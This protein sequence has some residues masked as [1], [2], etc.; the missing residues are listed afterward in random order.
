MT[1]VTTDRAGAQKNGAT[2]GEV[3]AGKLAEGTKELGF[4]RELGI[5]GAQGAGETQ[6]AQG[7]AKEHSKGVSVELQTRRGRSR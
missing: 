5:W 6:H 3:W 2:T 1:R 7:T 4:E